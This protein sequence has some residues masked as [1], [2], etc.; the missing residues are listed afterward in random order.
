MLR[1]ASQRTQVHRLIFYLEQGPNPAEGARAWPD[2][3]LCSSRNLE[4]MSSSFV[5]DA[6][7]RTEDFDYATH[8]FCR[9]KSWPL[10]SLAF[11]L[12]YFG[13]SIIVASQGYFLDPGA[14]L[15]RTQPTSQPRQFNTQ[16][17]EYSV[18]WP[19]QYQ[20]SN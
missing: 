12:F 15:S 4:L 2:Q 5:C 17:H 11:F 3:L 9:A 6:G 18:T 19:R 7:D 16:P 1:D 14:T 10:R 8:T 20:G 13:A